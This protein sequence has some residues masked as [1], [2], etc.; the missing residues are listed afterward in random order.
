[1]DITLRGIFLTSEQP[2][3][4]ARFYEQVALLELETI[5]TPEHYVYWRC[6]RDGMQLAIHDAEAFAAYA[7]PAL[8]GSNLIHLYFRIDNHEAFLAHLATLQIEPVDID[9]TA[10][11]VRDPDGRMVLF[12]TA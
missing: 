4:T 10:V 12:G 5:G 6:D 3:V 11:T 1:M 9:P 2:Q 7:H 8:A